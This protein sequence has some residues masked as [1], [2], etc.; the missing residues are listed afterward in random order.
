VTTRISA[1]GD[2][3]QIVEIV[4]TE[5]LLKCG[6]DVNEQRRRLRETMTA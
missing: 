6:S 5:R 4:L 3:P 2:V 1:A